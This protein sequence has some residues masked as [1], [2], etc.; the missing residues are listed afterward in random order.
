MSAYTSVAQNLLD[1]ADIVRDRDLSTDGEN[2]SYFTLAVSTKKPWQ[3]TTKTSRLLPLDQVANT[4]GC[5]CR[6]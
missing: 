4:D 3:Q 1:T 5:A 6:V 2:G